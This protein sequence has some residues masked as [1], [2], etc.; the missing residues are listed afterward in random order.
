M[1][2]NLLADEDDAL[3]SLMKALLATKDES[4]QFSHILEFV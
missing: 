4:Q 2:Y 3:I 1:L